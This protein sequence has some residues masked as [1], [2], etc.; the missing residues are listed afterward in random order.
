MSRT[1]RS[2]WEALLKHSLLGG[3]WIPRAA[4][5]HAQGTHQSEHDRRAISGP[6]ARVTGGHPRSLRTARYAWS[7]QL[8]GVTTALP[9]LIV[10]VRFSS[11]APRTKAQAGALGSSAAESGTIPWNQL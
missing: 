11:P 5:P 1:R 4:A 3:Y 10:R 6:L 8:A 2:S 9:K 7:A